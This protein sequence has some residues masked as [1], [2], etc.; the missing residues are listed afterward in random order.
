MDTGDSVLRCA[1]DRPG[2]DDFK[3]AIEGERLV[4]VAEKVEP[5]SPAFAGMAE[6]QSRSFSAATR[7][8]LGLAR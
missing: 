4:F 8:P 2:Y 6:R 7:M 5:D 3:N 1:P